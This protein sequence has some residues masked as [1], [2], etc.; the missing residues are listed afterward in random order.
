MA[1]PRFWREVPV[2]IP[3]GEG[4]LEG[5]VDLLFEEEGGLVLVDYKTD[6]VD[7]EHL[8]GAKQRYRLQGGAYALALRKATGMPVKEV[9][10]L[11]L[12]ADHPETMTDVD[13]MSADAE[14][15]ARQYLKGEV[16]DLP[17]SYFGEAG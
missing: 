17:G 5:F 13:E 11:F 14:A 1:A 3:V 15:R 10:F 16:E 6:A 2:A 4:V 12:H 9:I 7:F 8:E